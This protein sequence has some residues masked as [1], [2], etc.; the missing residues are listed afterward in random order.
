MRLSNRSVLFYSLCILMRAMLPWNSLQTYDTR[1]HFFLWESEGRDF[2]IFCTSI[3]IMMCCWLCINDD[4]HRRCWCSR[5]C[6]RRC[7]ISKQ[8]AWRRRPYDEHTF[9]NTR[10]PR[11]STA[12][13]SREDNYC[14][15]MPSRRYCVFCLIS[16]F[17]L[18]VSYTV[19][20]YF[21]LFKCTILHQC[22]TKFWFGF[23]C[24]Y[25]KSLRFGLK[26][27]I[28]FPPKV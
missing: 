1:M 19:L 11:S 21:A 9:S 12:H 5:W 16:P 15:R 2:S 23:Y 14:T 24:Y 22:I 10:V 7:R 25:H 6:A 28:L 4:I 8:V 20:V 27:T 26:S 18:V 17:F 13:W 3:V